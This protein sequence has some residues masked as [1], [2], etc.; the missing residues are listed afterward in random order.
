VFEPSGCANCG[1]PLHGAYCHVCGQKDADA[2]WQSLSDV[3]RQLRRELVKFDFKSLH[4]LAA[5]LRPGYLPQQFIAGRRQRYLT[6]LKTYLLCA[7]IYFFVAP[8]V[9]GFN[10]VELLR[11]DA[12]GTVHA[13]VAQRISETHL[14]RELFDERF[15]LRMQSVY[16]L[17]PGFSAI[18]ALLILRLLYRSRAIAIRTH[19]VFAV[20]YVAFLYLADIAIGAAHYT[21]PP[22]TAWL[23]FP[24][25]LVAIGPYLFLALRRVYGE[26]VGRTLGKAAAFLVLAFLA[27]I[28]IN[29]GARAL[30]FALT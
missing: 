18:A 23:V 28:P 1:T 27:D 5:L 22:S 21:L 11:Q 16:T 13:A 29:I 7:A 30:L 14:S 3:V 26:A 9:A 12:D 4:T 15:R 6:P 17:M 19:I 20:F 8:S 25:Q 10:L 24:L 2:D